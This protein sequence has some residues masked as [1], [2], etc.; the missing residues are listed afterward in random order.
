MNI[1]AITAHPDDAEF[2]CAGALILL[3]KLCHKLAIATINNGSCGAA[4]MG[5]KKNHR[6]PGQGSVCSNFETWT[7]TDQLK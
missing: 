5:P 6:C 4:E 7:K 1:L 2:Q 3:K